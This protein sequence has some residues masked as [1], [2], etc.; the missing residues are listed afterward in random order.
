MRDQEQSPLRIPLD[1]MI[2]DTL[3]AILTGAGAYGL[4]AGPGGLLPILAKPGVAWICIAFGVGLMALA[5]AQIVKR[6]L[7][8]RARGPGADASRK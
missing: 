7:Q 2:V 6:I 8:Q 5:M 4:L 1:W 3:G